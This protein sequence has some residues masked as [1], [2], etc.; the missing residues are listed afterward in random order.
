METKEQI[1]K[2]KL[3]IAEIKENAWKWRGV[4][5]SHE[6]HTS[7][8]EKANK[9]LEKGNVRDRIANLENKNKAAEAREQ[10]RRIIFLQDKKIKSDKIRKA[11]ALQEGWK[12][13]MEKVSQWEETD[14]IVLESEEKAMNDCS[15]QDWTLEGVSE[16]GNLLEDLLSE[17]IAFSELKEHLRGTVPLN[18]YNNE[19]VGTVPQKPDLRLL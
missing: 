14:D 13:L 17:V 1:L 10:E 11:A 15:Y 19:L 2:R 18:Y 3:E 9:R 8:M 5:S 7:R 16:A 6:E 12:Q 4:K